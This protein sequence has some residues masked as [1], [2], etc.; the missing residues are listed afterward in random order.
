MNHYKVLAALVSAA[1]CAVPAWTGVQQPQGATAAFTAAQT[2]LPWA[3]PLAA[4]GLHR[5]TN[6]GVQDRQP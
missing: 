6:D 2:L 3:F 4:P 5:A 1:L